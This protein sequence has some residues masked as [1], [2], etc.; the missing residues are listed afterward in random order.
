MRFRIATAAALLV[1]AL[2]GPAAA[3]ESVR[4]RIASL[5]VRELL[6]TPV[7]P[8]EETVGGVTVYFLPDHELPLVTFYAVFKGGVSNLPRDYL[9]AASAMPTM[10]RSGGTATLP[11]DS[12][13]LRIESLALA[14]SFG[15][16][17]GSASSW[18]NSL[19][20]HLDEAVPLWA[21]MLREPRFDPARVEQWRGAELERVRRRGDDPAS[22]AYSRFN[23]IMYGDHPIG[24]EMNAGDL[25][26]GDV[27]EERLRHVH[28]A[29][30]CPGNMVLGVAGDVDWDRAE[31][32][33]G[34]V[35][36]GWPP[37]S[38]NLLEYPVPDIRRDPG[39]FV[40]HKPIEQS[41]VIAAHSS[42]LRQGDTPAYFASRIGNSILGASG[43]SSRL[44]TEVRTRE[45][46]AYG[47]SSLWTASRRNDG[48]L[49]AVTRTRPE[50]TLAA[51]RLLLEVP[52]SMR[53]AP[54]AGEEVARV[55][56]EAVNGFVFN[57]GTPLQV[58]SRSMTYHTLDLPED[59]LE[60]YLRGIQRVTPGA[61][62]DVFRD[63]LDPARMTILLVGDTTR[64][65]G[66]PSELGTV[67][68]LEEDPPPPPP[69]PS[70]P[71]GSPRSP[72]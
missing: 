64:F 37:C 27:A 24:W 1:P 47:A 48:L 50:S 56:N 58:V 5:E 22:L 8:R 63:Q 13:D 38:G 26:P 66:S 33:L 15:Q 41:V 11:P 72:G 71:R 43:L 61:V 49:G 10:L 14:M 6:F 19:A 34:Q 53:D 31:A 57:F 68:I 28:E 9:A 45:G 46:L 62:H 7:R 55:V 21:A 17:G 18:V 52:G 70:P 67:T 12:V 20:E 3:Q 4:D 39:V 30:F 32:L 35:L 42:S 29:L 69:D 2:P 36:S 60:R 23:R 65:D 54:P 44:N 16:G 40:I 25:E 51:A 59:W